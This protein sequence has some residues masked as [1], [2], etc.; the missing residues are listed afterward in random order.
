MK[1]DSWDVRVE[2]RDIYYGDAQAVYA[3][4]FHDTLLEVHERYPRRRIALLQIT[5]DKPIYRQSM[6]G[7]R[8]Q[9]LE[10][11]AHIRVEVENA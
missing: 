5:T 2:K 1:T 4:I 11:K 7:P 9:W 8:Y 6:E 10:Y 3:K